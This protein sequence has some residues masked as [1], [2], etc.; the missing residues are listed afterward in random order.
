MSSTAASAAERSRG[1]VLVAAAALCWSLGG[2]LARLVA[3]DT[4]TTV[5]WRS[6]FAA[7]F[8]WGGVIAVFGSLI[9]NDTSTLVAHSVGGEAA[10]EIAGAVISAPFA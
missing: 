2:L 6:I 7:A 5:F 9:I 4:W 3:T 10:A 8:L 1:V